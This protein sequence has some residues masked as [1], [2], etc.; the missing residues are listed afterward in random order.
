MKTTTKT[1]AKPATLQAM[2]LQEVRRLQAAERAAK[3]AFWAA[4]GVTG[5]KATTEHKKLH[6]ALVAATKARQD[7]MTSYATALGYSA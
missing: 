3:D 1:S 2:T 7:A 5:S 6:A 4:A